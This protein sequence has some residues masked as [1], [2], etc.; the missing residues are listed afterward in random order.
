MSPDRDTGASWEQRLQSGSRLQ[1]L[2]SLLCVFFCVNV[3]RS[4][5]WA[6]AQYCLSL[7]H[8]EVSP[9]PPT[10]PGASSTT[11][12]ALDQGCVWGVCVWVCF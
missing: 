7:A 2:S 6:C 5:A 1:P 12:P 8:Q 10:E 4:A 3:S 9:E 11:S